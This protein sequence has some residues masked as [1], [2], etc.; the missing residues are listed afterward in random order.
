MFRICIPIPLNDWQF[1]ARLLNSKFYFLNK[2]NFYGKVSS[3]Y[4]VACRLKN[5][6]TIRLLHRLERMRSIPT[7]DARSHWHQS[8]CCNHRLHGKFL[9]SI[10]QVSHI[11]TKKYSWSLLVPKRTKQ[12]LR[13]L[14]PIQMDPHSPYPK[15]PTKTHCKFM[16]HQRI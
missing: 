10:S 5:T 15:S 7:I 3:N 2:P 12:I 8:A 1:T 16:I 6:G 14:I 4:S 9:R 13:E 11:G